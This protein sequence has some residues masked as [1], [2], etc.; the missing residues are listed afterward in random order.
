MSDETQ[1]PE[2]Q[3]NP[4]A[5]SEAVIDENK[6]DPAVETPAGAPAE[7]Q[8]PSLE[9][10]NAELKDKLLRAMAEAENIRRR[11][12][13][14]RADIARYAAAGFARDM[15]T[16][17]DNLHR[18]IE[19]I[20]A[21]ERAA[22]SD[23]VRAAVEGVEVTERSLLSTF[24]RHGIRVIRPLPGEKFDANLHEAMFEVPGAEHAAGTVVHVVEDGYMMGDRLLRAARV[25]VAKGA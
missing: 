12:E 16:V 8:K 9:A 7:P 4:E 1:K 3:A 22:A 2:D 15:L 18:A 24:E 21:E 10:E 6:G 23:A 5:A 14:E 17:A 19:S 13:R 11:L 20:S 25:G